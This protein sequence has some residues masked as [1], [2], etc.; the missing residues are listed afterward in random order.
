[1]F[2]MPS[3]MNRRSAT[4]APWANGCFTPVLRTTHPLGVATRATRPL[5]ARNARA[6]GGALG[7]GRRAPAPGADRPARA[8]KPKRHTHTQQQTTPP[9]H[10]VLGVRP[11]H[12]QPS[13]RDPI[14]RL[15][16]PHRRP[17]R[18]AADFAGGSS[19]PWGARPW[20]LI[21]HRAAEPPQ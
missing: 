21:R 9:A 20:R 19:D 16:Q 1:M 7:G 10:V 17:R 11:A 18:G 3:R 14:W 8:H 4:R 12:R 2:R 13:A 5:G 15:R 6:P